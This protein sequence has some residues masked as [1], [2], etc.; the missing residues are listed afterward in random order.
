MA[1]GAGTH[2]LSQLDGEGQGKAAGS[3]VTNSREDAAMRGCGRYVTSL[4]AGRD[5]T[6]CWV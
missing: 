2:N 5:V 4:T 3:A 6:V 1:D